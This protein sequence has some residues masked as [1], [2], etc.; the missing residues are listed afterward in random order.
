[1]VRANGL[2]KIV[3]FGIA[4]LSAPTLSDAEAAT[5][6]KGGT[7]PGMIIGT[8]NYMS[9]EQARGR[10]VDART[11]IF[12]FGVVL[13]EMIAGN[14]PFEG[15]NALEMIGAILKDEPKPLDADVPAEIQKII[16]KCLR[17]DAGERYQTIK[18]VLIDIQDVK[19]DLEFQDKLERS[20]V[21]NRNKN[22]TRILQ[23]ATVDEIN[24]TTTNQTVA[25][26]PKTKYL[27]NGLLTL[28]LAVGSDADIVIF[29]PDTE[30][31]F[32]VDNEHMNVDYSSYE[33]WK[34]KG[35]VETVL[36]RGRVVI[37][38]GEHKG[39][40]GDGQFLKRGECAKI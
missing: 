22:K 34:I 19:Q 32:G 38:N 28:L 13:C 2:V 40:A 29:N 14:L 11:D 37:E 16:H 5:A 15:E 21:S 36:S 7:L 9:P 17:K 6:I 18:D 8:A 10:E 20:I 26:N 35:K 4:K 33:G 3:E 31:T 1:M 25:G 30:H 27:A 39:K 24:Q 12:S 23:A